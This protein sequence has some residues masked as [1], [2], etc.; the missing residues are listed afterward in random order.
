MTSKGAYNASLTDGNG[1]PPWL[2]DHKIFLFRQST[3]R[4]LEQV[5]SP[6]W[7][8]VTSNQKQ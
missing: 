6:V 3:H 4:K 1:D 8:Q 2:A 7:D 5:Q